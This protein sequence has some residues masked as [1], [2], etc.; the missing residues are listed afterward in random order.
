MSHVSITQYWLELTIA[1]FSILVMLLIFV[2]RG[3]RENQARIW[4]WAREETHII[5]RKL[6]NSAKLT[7]AEFRDLRRW[8]RHEVRTVYAEMIE[9]SRVLGE[10]GKPI[11]TSIHDRL[12]RWEE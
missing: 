3:I 4:N 10:Q 9:M 12:T 11:E 1:A 8:V 7:D 6:D 5:E 2:L